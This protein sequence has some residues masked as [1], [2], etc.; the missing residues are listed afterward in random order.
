MKVIKILIKDFNC[1]LDIK[2][3]NGVSP[4]LLSIKSSKLEIM[5]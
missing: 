4:L 2:T 1:N 3:K 5:K